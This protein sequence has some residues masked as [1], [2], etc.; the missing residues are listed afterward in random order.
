[1]LKQGVPALVFSLP[2][3][4]PSTDIKT[5]DNMRIN[6]TIVLWV[7]AVMVAWGAVEGAAQNIT[8]NNNLSFGNIISGIPKTISKRDAGAAAEYHISGIAG[9]EVSIDFTLQTYMNSGGSH[10]QLVF[11]ETDC[12][13]DSSAV[14]DQSHPGADNLDPWHTMTYRL[15]ANGLTIWLGGMVIPGLVQKPGSYSATIVLSVGYTNN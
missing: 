14:P 9:D 4:H 15:G 5:W 1:M 11:R 7:L 3:G 6:H 8:I 13:M 2:T 12:A 10:M